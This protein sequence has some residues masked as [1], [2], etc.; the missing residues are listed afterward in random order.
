MIESVNLKHRG[1]MPRRLKRNFKGDKSVIR[2][3]YDPRIPSNF[4]G[5][6][7]SS[8]LINNE[9]NLQKHLNTKYVLFKQKIFIIVRKILLDLGKEVK[10]RGKVSGKSTIKNTSC[11]FRFLKLQLL[12]SCE[13]IISITFVPPVLIN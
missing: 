2:F 4:N 12:K 1:E 6:N 10:I 7:S 13:L 11:S 9:E 3:H 8:Y 5:E